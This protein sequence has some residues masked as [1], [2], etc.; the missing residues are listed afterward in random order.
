MVETVTV[1]ELF[2]EEL[3]ALEFQRK[4]LSKIKT[5]QAKRVV[6]DLGVVI[7]YFR[8]RLNADDGG[9]T[10]GIYPTDKIVH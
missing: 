4:S 3:E 2:Q 9:A 8:A 1:E 7:K 5:P 10:M 6:K